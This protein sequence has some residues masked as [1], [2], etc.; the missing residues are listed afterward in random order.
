MLDVAVAGMTCVQLSSLV[1]V[2][3]LVKAVAPERTLSVISRVL[4]LAVYTLE[5]IRAW[6][7]I[8][9]CLSR[10]VGLR[11]G[12]AAPSHGP[13]VF[14]SMWS[15]TLLT[16]STLSTT[17]VDRMSPVP[18]VATL[19]NPRVHSSPQTVAV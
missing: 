14:H 1:G 3:L 6:S 2:P 5:G 10:R 11:V 4:T 8:C 15:T 9:G 17:S 12:F 7:A 19:G 16:L 13:V 18:A